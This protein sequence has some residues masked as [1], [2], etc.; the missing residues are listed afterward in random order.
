[1]AVTGQSAVA[2][3]DTEGYG[4]ITGDVNTKVDK[5]CQGVRC[6][7]QRKIKMIFSFISIYCG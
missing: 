3:R 1:M 6:C 7:C 2:S 4:V 5:T